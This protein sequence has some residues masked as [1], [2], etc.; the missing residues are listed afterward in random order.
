M[1]R[2]S[3]YEIIF[4]KDFIPYWSEDFVIKEFKYTV[5]W[6]YVIIDLN[7]KWHLETFTKK[8]CK[9]QIKTS[10]GLKK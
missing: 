7:R 9:K 5:T 4:E 8:S 10:L 3:K 2:I 6:I 1:I